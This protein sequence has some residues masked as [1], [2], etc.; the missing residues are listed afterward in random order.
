MSPG[1]QAIFYFLAFAMFVVAAILS[2]TLK[3]WWNLLVAAGLACWVFV[4]FWVNV[5]GK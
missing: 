3:A 5:K 2:F 4:P 1:A